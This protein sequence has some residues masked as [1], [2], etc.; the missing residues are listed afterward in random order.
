MVK[1]QNLPV[2]TNPVISLYL[3]NG[4][5]ESKGRLI[6]TQSSQNYR[7]Y[8][9]GTG[10]EGVSKSSFLGDLFSL[11]LSNSLLLCCLALAE[12]AWHHTG[13]SRECC[14]FA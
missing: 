6:H 8:M 9:G 7:A 10:G 2:T 11:C 12:I 1:Y 4:H 14:G 13:Q 3:L 5:G